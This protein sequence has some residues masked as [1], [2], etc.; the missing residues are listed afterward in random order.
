[1]ATSPTIPTLVTTSSVMSQDI[2]ST[3]SITVDATSAS[4]VAP[5]LNP[6]SAGVSGNLQTETLALVQGQ[7]CHV[8]RNPA[9]DSGWQMTPISSSTS[10]Q[11]VAAGTAYATSSSPS[12]YGF[13]QDGVSLYWTQLQSD[14]VTWSTPTAMPTL[15]TNLRVAYSPAGQ[16]ILYAGTAAGDL[17]LVY[18]NPD[19]NV[20][21]FFT[22]T[23]T[24][25]VLTSGDFSLCMTSE[26]TWWLAANVG[27]SPNLYEGTLPNPPSTPISP[28]S[29]DTISAFAS[30]LAQVSLSF[31]AASQNTLMFLLV[32]T[33]GQLYV[34]VQGSNTIQPIS[35]STVTQASGVVSAADGTLHV[36]SVDSNQGLWV[37]H[38]DSQNPWNQDGTPNWAP[39]IPLERARANEV[40]SVATDMNPV[41][42]PTLFVVDGG[43]ASLRLHAQD[44]TTQMWNSGQLLQSTAQAY[45]VSRFRTEVNVLGPYSNILPNQAVSVQVAP[46]GSA[47][48]LWVAGQI[49]QVTSAAPVTLPTDARGKLTFS[50][51]TNAG[52]ATPNLVFTA[53]GLTAPVSIVPSAPLHTYLS[54]NGPLNLT[55]PNGALP[56]F[57]AQGATLA[58]ATIGPN[59]P[60]LAPN[61]QGSLAGVAAQAIQNTALLALN[62]LPAGT[63]GYSA[64]FSDPNNATFKIH[65]SREE[66]ASQFAAMRLKAA[67]LGSIL[68]DIDH[69]FGDVWEALKNGAATLVNFVVDAVTKAIQMTVQLGNT[70]Q[71]V[72]NT[73]IQGVEQAAQAIAGVF[74]VVAADIGDVINW[75]E[76][77][78]DFGAIWRT[79]MA[80][81]QA[82]GNMQP[83]LKQIV[84]AAS[85]GLNGWFSAQETA[86][87]NSFNT[88]VQQFGQTATL[89]SLSNFQTPGQPPDN[90]TPI[91]GNATTADLNNNVHSNWMQDK[92]SSYTPSTSPVTPASTLT[93]P[94]QT[95]VTEVQN[96]QGDFMTALQDFSQ[97]V[98]ILSTDPS[99]FGTLGISDFLGGIQ[100]LIN[101][102]LSLC[103]ALAQ[104]LLALVDDGIQ[105]IVDML[106]TPLDLGPINSFWS[107][108]A[109]EAGYPDDNQLTLSGL[110]CL[111]AAFP[112]TVLYKLVAGPS[113]EPFPTGA[114]PTPSS[115]SAGLT[116][117]S[118]FPGLFCDTGYACNLCAGI[119]Q[120]LY[121]IPAAVGDAL[122]NPAGWLTT[123]LTSLKVAMC[124]VIFFLQNGVPQST[125]QWNHVFAGVWGAALG[126]PLVACVLQALSAQLY[127]ILASQVTSDVLNFLFSLY[128][129]AYFA[130]DLT[131]DIA[132]WVKSVPTPPFTVVSGLLSPLPSLFAWMRMSAFSQDP[133]WSWIFRPASV[134]MDY[135]GYVGSGACLVANAFEIENASSSATAGA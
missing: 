95:F 65:S 4:P 130:F 106:N 127:Q 99:Q 18:P 46:N 120:A 26:Q 85:S 52:L 78:F 66:V 135:I 29:T 10:I 111:A 105:V 122:G 57:D 34:Y 59:G 68:G 11:E 56:V 121:V 74:Q 53:T 96:A 131:V 87:N 100:N 92:I 104:G 134:V 64:D 112:C 30:Q 39:Y 70:I 33:S 1:M 31:Y 24:L 14:G 8:T 49:Y 113:G 97:V 103:D 63:T 55:N 67:N 15:G 90:T 88:L 62:Q 50:T 69:F 79:K 110:L 43:D 7:V 75:L 48:D 81:E 73:A 19:S 94:W 54:G 77:V 71:A 83:V 38:Q 42:A 98:S 9:T 84:G 3:S 102:A 128:G 89:S 126:L 72:V 132:S 118:A 109:T 13:F 125:V 133:D 17:L 35:N 20:G 114:L 76:A 117:T 16:V 21:G 101:S 23:C 32:D 86:I 123:F 58:A 28:L 93:S 124:A 61:A 37:L 45:E 129:A 91:A 115:D 51:L 41:D 36:Y 12:A 82:L 5:F 40:G 44:P 27:N 25:G 22:T 116:A 80:F 47:V 60:P 6:N 108:M 2:I 107:W 119:L